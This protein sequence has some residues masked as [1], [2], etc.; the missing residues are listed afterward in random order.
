MRILA[1]CLLMFVVRP[2][3]A[4]D[5]MRYGGSEVPRVLTSAEDKFLLTVPDKDGLRETYRQ[6]LA[7]NVFHVPK[8]GKFDGDVKS[9][10]RAYQVLTFNAEYAEHLARKLGA[11]GLTGRESKPGATGTKK[12]DQGTRGFPGEPGIQGEPGKPAD[13]GPVVDV[14]SETRDTVTAYLRQQPRY[15]LVGSGAQPAAYP[16]Y[17]YKR[18]FGDFVLGLANAASFPLGM[19]WLRP[20]VF[21]DS[22]S[23]VGNSGQ[24]QGGAGGAGG[25]GPTISNV[26]NPTISNVGNPTVRADGGSARIDPINITQTQGQQQQQQQR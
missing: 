23:V 25:A 8:S 13:L 22:S 10:W 11:T 9:V 5:K 6:L 2:V 4:T 19:K 21:N 17:Y 16:Q 3:L 26:G 20:S 15:V 7:R 1:L 12:G 24:I 14:L 18:D